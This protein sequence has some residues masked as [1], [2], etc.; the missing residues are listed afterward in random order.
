MP[1]QIL[2]TIF[3]IHGAIFLWFPETVNDDSSPFKLIKYVIIFFAVAITFNK[4]SLKAIFLYCVPLISILFPLSLIA[5]NFYPD[6]TVIK[7]LIPLL[8]VIML[9]KPILNIPNENKYIIALI[10]YLIAVTLG[11]YEFNDPSR[12][13]SP[14]ST[15]LFG[16]RISSIFV[17][18]NNYGITMLFL[19]LY[20]LKTSNKVILNIILSILFIPVA[21][22]SFSKTAIFIAAFYLTFRYKILMFPLLLSGLISVFLTGWIRLNEIDLPSLIARFNYNNRFIDLIS[23]NPIFPFFKQMQ[24]TDN[25]YLNIYGHFGII[26]IISLLLFYFI[27]LIALLL[28]RKNNLALILSLFLIV[29]FTTNILYLWPL[30]YMHWFF[31]FYCYKS[32]NSKNNN[33]IKLF[34]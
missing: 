33:Q 1:L 30:A 4:N 34:N 21:I 26:G 10:I 11:F 5:H 15:G 25:N 3:F 6:M 29:E 9:Y 16:P 14:Y 32:L 12:S 13:L 22:L 27:L 7:Y 8:T 31:I 23:D 17:N 18:P 19:L 2:I 24:Y 20:L 28:N